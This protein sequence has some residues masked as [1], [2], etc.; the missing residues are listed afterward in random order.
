MKY[1]M[2]IIFT[3]LYGSM[4]FNIGVREGSKPVYKELIDHTTML[5]N[6]VAQQ[7]EYERSFK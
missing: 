4:C 2:Y 6:V 1:T 7:L 5:T 3:I